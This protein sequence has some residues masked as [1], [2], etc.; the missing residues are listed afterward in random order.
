MNSSVIQQ[1]LGRIAQ[2]VLLEGPGERG[3]R[4][5]SS[6]G[7]LAAIVQTSAEESAAFGAVSR[8]AVQEGPVQLPRA[9]QKRVDAQQR[10]RPATA[11]LDEQEMSIVEL[12]QRWAEQAWRMVRAAVLSFAESHAVLL[13]VLSFGLA[14]VALQAFAPKIALA[15]T[16]AAPKLFASLVSDVA[17]SNGELAN[18]ANNLYWTAEKRM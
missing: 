5:R 15:I 14:L 13:R 1:E 17:A 18:N 4:Q 11:P 12:A 8:R 9:L 16:A 3:E 6:L 2:E 10:G 7:Q